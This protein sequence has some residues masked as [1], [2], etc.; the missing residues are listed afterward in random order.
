MVERSSSFVVTEK[1]ITLALCSYKRA[2]TLCTNYQVVKIIVNSQTLYG[3]EG[4]SFKVVSGSLPK[5]DD[6]NRLGRG[7][8]KTIEMREEGKR[9]VILFFR[10]FVH[11]PFATLTGLS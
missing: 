8:W 3:H 5:L 7:R 4:C 10:L 1:S 6:R 11:H 9:Q 2:V